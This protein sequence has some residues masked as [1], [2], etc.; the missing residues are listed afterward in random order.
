M[1]RIL[2]ITDLDGTLLGTDSLVSTESQRL[3]NDAISR[4]ALFSIAT[5]RTPG[6]VCDLMKGID[7]NLPGIVLTGAAMW[8][9]NK[10]VYSDVKYL[11]PEAVAFA[12]SVYKRHK[13]PAFI[14]TLRN[15][16]LEVYH[17]G[18]LHGEERKF[19]EER[20][21]NPYKRFLVDENGKSEIPDRL[22]DAVLLFGI[23]PTHAALGVLADLKGYPLINPMFYH[24]HLGPELAE[25]EAFSNETSKAAAVERLAERCGAD[26]VVVFG[27]NLNDLSMMKVADEAIAVENAV[28]EVKEVADKVIGANT[29]D[30]VARYIFEHT[31]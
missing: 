17:F 26:K 1:K 23:Q 21:H 24:D 11:T 14:Y 3:M 20:R 25:M 27:D 2:Y 12:R 7:I 4:G 22:E 31:I 10:K 8:D 19:M 9:F 18:P 13:V 5:A 16:L 15:N 30:A 6:T 28:E 29:T